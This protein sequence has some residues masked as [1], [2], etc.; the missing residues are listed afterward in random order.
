[1][2]VKMDLNVLEE[3]IYELINKSKSRFCKAQGFGIGVGLDIL[4]SYLN[5]VADRAIKIDDPIITYFLMQI[6]VLKPENKEEEKSIEERFEKTQ[7]R[8]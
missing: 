3:K 2:Q 1:M 6:G 4:N 5:K 7:M 8:D